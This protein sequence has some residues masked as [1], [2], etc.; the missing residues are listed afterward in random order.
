L[1]LSI[2]HLLKP[3][4]QHVVMMMIKGSIPSELGKLKE[5]QVSVLS[6][7]E[8]RGVNVMKDHDDD[9]LYERYHAS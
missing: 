9:K 2:I 5:L 4:Y 1:G 8:L 3:P 7:N 6:F